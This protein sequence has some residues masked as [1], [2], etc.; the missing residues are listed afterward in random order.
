MCAIE[1]PFFLNVSIKSLTSAEHFCL[2]KAKKGF[3]GFF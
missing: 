3:F 2:T 1:E